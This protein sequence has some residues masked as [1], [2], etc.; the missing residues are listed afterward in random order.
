[1]KEKKSS[2][3]KILSRIELGKS[4]LI[5]FFAGLVVLAA[6]FILMSQGP[7]DNPLSRSVS[8]LVLLFG[9]LIVFPI[10]IF[11]RGKSNSSK[12]RKY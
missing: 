9:Y 1:M 12:V 5:L 3:N 11:Y 8:P 7:W 6:G 4:N 2:E 10:A